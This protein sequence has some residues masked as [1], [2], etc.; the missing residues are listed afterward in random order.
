MLSGCSDAEKAMTW[1][2]IE[3]DNGV[4]KDTLRALLERAGWLH[5]NALPG[6]QAALARARSYRDADRIGPYLAFCRECAAEAVR[7]GALSVVVR[8]WP[9][10]AAGAFADELIDEDQFQ[11]L[12]TR[13]VEEFP[14]PDA[15]VE[16]R[17]AQRERVQRVLRRSATPAG[18]DNLDPARAVR[19][20]WALERIAAQW[21]VP[22]QVV[23]T[24]S[25]DPEQ[26]VAVTQRWLHSLEQAVRWKRR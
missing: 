24:T 22:W 4:G 10:T 14:R 21:D 3:G 12:V 11:L 7:R 25:L 6:P 19:H 23:D 20:R 1:L 16:L 15:V 18:T 13:C 8:Y 26:V 9:S 17:C 2:V 5:I